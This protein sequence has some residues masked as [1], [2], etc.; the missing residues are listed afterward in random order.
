MCAARSARSSRPCVPHH[1]AYTSISA[2]ASGIPSSRG[3]AASNSSARRNG[4]VTQGVGGLEPPCVLREYLYI[5]QLADLTPW[6]PDAIRTMMSRGLFK[7]GVH[8]F[9]PQGERGR[10]IF[11]WQSVVR[12]IQGRDTEPESVDTADRI[13]MADGRVISLDEAKKEAQRLLR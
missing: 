8:Y 2:G 6:S 4:G 3:P 13:P 1:Q 5:E 12:Y 7:Q 11:R 10:V 9:K